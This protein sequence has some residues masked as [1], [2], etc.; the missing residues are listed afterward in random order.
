MKFTITFLFILIISITYSKAQTVINAETLRVDILKNVN[1]NKWVGSASLNFF[2]KKN[3]T[4]FFAISTNVGIGYNGGDNLWLIISDISFSKLSGDS[5]INSGSQHFRYN[6]K[7][8]KSIISLEAFLQGQYDDISNIDFRGLAGIGPRFD[9]SRAEDKVVDKD[10]RIRIFIG[11]LVMYEH[12]KSTEL[13]NKIIQKDIRSSN[14]LSFTLPFNGLKIVSTTYYQPKIEL[15]KDYRISSDLNIFID[16]PKKEVTVNDTYEIEYH[17]MAYTRTVTKS[18][19]FWENMHFN[20][21]FRYYY[22]AFPVSGIPKTQYGIT[23]GLSY[24]F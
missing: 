11:T 22:D 2:I 8:E 19:S 6:R 9:F 1:K 7:F 4:D 18:N 20:I 14:Y 23:N 17:Y 13:D 21:S 12:E 24:D 3:T 16:F 5:F 10:K 15:L